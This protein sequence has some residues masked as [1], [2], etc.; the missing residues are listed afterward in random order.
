[1]VCAFQHILLFFAI[2]FRSFVVLLLYKSLKIISIL[3]KIGHTKI[4]IDRFKYQVIKML[5]TH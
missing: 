1:M 4:V 5:T 2:P 3:V